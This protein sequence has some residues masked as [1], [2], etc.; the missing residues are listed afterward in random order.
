MGVAAA[1]CGTLVIGG[2]PS[3]W[4]PSDEGSAA[5]E[6]ARNGV[7]RPNRARWSAGN[8]FIPKGGSY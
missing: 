5:S 6:D 7:R 8:P 1:W 4:R 3:N 2:R